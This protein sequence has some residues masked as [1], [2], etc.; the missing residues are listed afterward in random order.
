[1][2][3]FTEK[4]A[5]GNWRLKGLPWKK[6]YPGT[7]V[8]TKDESGILYGAL[9]KLKDYED[10]GLTPEEVER[11][12]EETRWVTDDLPPEDELVLVQVSGWPN[13]HLEMVNSF[14]LAS[15]SRAGG[16]SM[17]DY[18]EWENAKPTAW[19]PI[20]I[21]TGSRGGNAE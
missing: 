8:I 19:H 6:T 7:Q 10:T 17:K 21:H 16:W 5:N 11:M 3:R 1:M 15:H 18:P 20:R 13:G 2:G 4:N 14:A 9:C 12:K